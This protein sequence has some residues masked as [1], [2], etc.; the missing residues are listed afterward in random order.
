MNP[1]SYV[2]LLQL[3]NMCIL[4]LSE[5]KIYG[6]RKKKSRLE[7]SQFQFLDICVLLSFTFVHWLL[8]MDSC[9]KRCSECFAFTHLISMQKKSLHSL[10]QRKWRLRCLWLWWHFCIFKKNYFL[11]LFPSSVST[12]KTRFSHYVLSTI[13][14][15]SF[16][17]LTTRQTWVKYTHWNPTDMSSVICVCSSTHHEATFE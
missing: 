17:P 14:L 13:W 4:N 5:K 1:N 9:T 11:Y 2:N 8:S 16:C 6:K 10:K 3:G 7:P 15:W 12:M